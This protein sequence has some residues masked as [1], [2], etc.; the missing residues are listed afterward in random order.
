MHSNIWIKHFISHCI[1]SAFWPIHAC[2][3]C[4]DLQVQYHRAKQRSKEYQ[5][6]KNT[7]TVYS[8]TPY[9][10]ILANHS[11][12]CL[13][14]LF[15]SVKLPVCGSHQFHPITAT[16]QPI[17]FSFIYFANLSSFIHSFSIY[18]QT[19]SMSFLIFL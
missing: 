16:F 14:V 13:P 15:K 6:N 4:C 17:Y 8:T 10:F 12:L 19:S 2:L 3:T 9:L 18:H 11:I 5:D 1:V 7:S